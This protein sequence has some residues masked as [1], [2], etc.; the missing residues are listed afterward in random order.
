MGWVRCVTFYRGATERPVL[1]DLFSE[2]CQWEMAGVGV[3]TIARSCS[4]QSFPGVPWSRGD[5]P[6]LFSPHSRALKEAGDQL[7]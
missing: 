5:S 1:T 7:W 2:P 3:R 4:L 6:Q